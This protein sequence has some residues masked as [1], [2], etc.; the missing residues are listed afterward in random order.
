MA[1]AITRVMITPVTSST[2]SE[3]VLVQFSPR[4]DARVSRDSPLAVRWTTMTGATYHTV[5]FED[6][7]GQSLLSAVIRKRG[8]S[9]APP[10]V[11]TRGPF[12]DDPAAR[13][14]RRRKG[15]S[16]PPL[17]MERADRRQ[18]KGW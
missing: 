13:E 7:N 14:R 6:G 1:V 5:D 2:V 18:V 11:R 10:R 15:K 3:R 17:L 16:A 9:Y 8:T 12:G 4:L